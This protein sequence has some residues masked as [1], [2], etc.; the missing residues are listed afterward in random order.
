MC[1]TKFTNSCVERK[2]KKTGKQRII[3]LKVEKL[4]NLQTLC[5]EEPLCEDD[6]EKVRRKQGPVKIFYDVNLS[7]YRGE[8]GSFKKLPRFDRCEF[9]RG[10]VSTPTFL[11]WCFLP[12]FKSFRGNGSSE[13]TR[14]P[15]GLVLGNSV[16]PLHPRNVGLS[17]FVEQVRERGD[18]RKS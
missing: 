8:G 15:E 11:G 9:S 16:K 6:G 7:I 10:C 17:K 12:K 2:M 18:M 4:L 3:P 1:K 5:R 13:S 14:S